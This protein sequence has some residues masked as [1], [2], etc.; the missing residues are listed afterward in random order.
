MSLTIPSNCL[1]FSL[2]LVFLQFFQVSS[3]QF[4]EADAV[5]EKYAA[6]YGG[7][8]AIL[9]IKDNKIAYQK[10]VGED[11]TINSQ[12]KVGAVSAWFTAALVMNFVDQGKIKLD[13]PVGKYLPIFNKYAK[14]YLTIR[15]CLTHTTGL[16]AEKGGVQKIFQKTKFETLEEQV[17]SFASG[18]EILN[19]PGKEIYFS[20]IGLNIVGRV[21]EVVGRK[22][23][24]RLVMEKIFRPLAM[25]KSTFS[26]ETIPNPSAG[27][28][29]TAA[30]L[31]KFMD[32]LLNKGTLNGKTVLTEQSVNTL[33]SI[34]MADAGRK[35]LPAAATG[36]GIALGSWAG[37][38]NPDG[39]PVILF[40]PGL[41]GSWAL[42]HLDRKYAF[43][44]VTKP[45]SKE[46]K[47][48]LY[49]EL[50]DIFNQK[51]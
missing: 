48:N 17:N 12:E 19:N 4:S 46:D 51:L 36:S 33:L 28:L 15:H 29:T 2:L 18:R 6:Q 37:E 9:A 40:N 50:L 1:K 20:N 8:L 13:D 49:L 44:V 47:P 39:Q 25:K 21:L 45:T 23:F 26:S 41:F 32:M 11:F 27:A 7:N 22:S 35:F 10:V 31:A 38:T 43:V 34:Q 42:L 24:D 14:R 30:D 16:E 3:A 5:A